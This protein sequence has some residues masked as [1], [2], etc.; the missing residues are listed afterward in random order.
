LARILALGT[1]IA[2]GM[3]VYAACLRLLGV[4]KFR[5]IRSAL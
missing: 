1:Q 3:I 4:V 2:L 5:F